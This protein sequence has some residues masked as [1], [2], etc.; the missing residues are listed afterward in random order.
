MFK[1]IINMVITYVIC[2]IIAYSLK[3]HIVRIANLAIRDQELAVGV[4]KYFPAHGK[5]A[6]ELAK[7]YIFAV[8]LIFWFIVVIFPLVFLFLYMSGGL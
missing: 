8:R 3:K 4:F 7:G 1:T 5:R 2:V 6:V